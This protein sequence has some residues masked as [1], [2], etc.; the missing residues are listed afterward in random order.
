MISIILDALILL[1]CVLII[2]HGIRAGF[3]KSVMGFLKGIVSFLVAYAFTPTVGAFINERFILPSVSGN[4]SDT[5]R[6][7]VEKSEGTSSVSD[8]FSEM[9][10]PLLQ[11]MNRYGATSGAVKE[12]LATA[13]GKEGAIKS[14]SDAIAGPI[15][16]TIS[17]CIAFIALFVASFIILVI[18]TAILDSVFHLPVLKTANKVLGAV[19]G[20]LEAFLFAYVISNLAGIACQALESVDPGL[21]G[22]K[23]VNDSFIMK[24]FVRTDF[25][26]L[27]SGVI[28][29]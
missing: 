24:F 26:K 25:L 22:E 14:A 19:F 3:I 20:V 10:E 27:I 15:S 18:V 5:I 23:V 11:I 21:F 2:V 6:S 17:N 8:L 7:L 4:I 12:S 28:K 29:G 1:I 16:G 13:T 9:P